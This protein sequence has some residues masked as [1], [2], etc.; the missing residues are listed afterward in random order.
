MTTL[1]IVVADDH[2]VVRAGVVMVLGLDADLEVI[3][4]ASNG[5]EAVAAAKEHEPDVVLMDLQ[6][7]ELDGVDATKRIIAE[8]P[9]TRVLI[10]TTYDNDQSILRAVEAGAAGYL[11]KDAPPDQLI[12]AIKT[13][14]VGGSVLP[15]DIAAKLM[16]KM[17]EPKMP[18][19][20]A[21]ELDV[22][23]CVAAGLT[24]GAT[25]TELSISLAT[26]KTHLIHIFQK[27]QVDD[28]TA[29]VMR[30]IE[31]GLITV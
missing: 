1:R 18:E 28:R 17:R 27:L 20:T 23:E 25:A 30:G 5:N 6:M 14:A 8:V 12:D 31:L 15:P 7:P 10:L 2:P 3:A 9:G 19:L 4:E 21:R 24:N 29:A 16:A 11:T 26:V 13:A 22:L